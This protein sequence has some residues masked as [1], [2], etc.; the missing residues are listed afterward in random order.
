MFLIFLIFAFLPKFF[1]FLCFFTSQSLHC[2]HQ[3]RCAAK[4]YPPAPRQKYK[5]I[6]EKY[7]NGPILTIIVFFGLIFSG[8]NPPWGIMHFFFCSEPGL[9]DRNSNHMPSTITGQRPLKENHLGMVSWSTAPFATQNVICIF[10][11]SGEGILL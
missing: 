3:L 2:T 7:E 1:F 5:K 8:P 6:T 10:L 11:L 9:R 4:S